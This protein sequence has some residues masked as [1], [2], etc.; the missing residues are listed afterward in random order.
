MQSFLAK[1]SSPTEFENWATFSQLGF[2][3]RHFDS[4]CG[5]ERRTYCFLFMSRFVL[6]SLLGEKGSK[7]GHFKLSLND[8]YHDSDVTEDC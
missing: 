4:C 6:P 7:M 1:E 8:Y 5:K 3:R 2:S